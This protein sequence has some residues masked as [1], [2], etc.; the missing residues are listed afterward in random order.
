MLASLSRGKLFTKLDMS[1]AYLHLLLD[2]DSREY[3]TIN[4]HKGL[5]C[6]V[7]QGIPQVAVYLLALGLLPLSW[8]VTGA[9]PGLLHLWWVIK[10]R[11]A[12]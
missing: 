5:H 4:T 1:H 9:S 3:V 12:R 2:K 7:L 11:P 8:G 10:S 6:S